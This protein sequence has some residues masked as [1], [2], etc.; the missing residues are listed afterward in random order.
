MTE[1]IKNGTDALRAAVYVKSRRGHLAHLARDLQIGINALEEFG[2]G[3]ANLAAETKV[4]MGPLLYPGSEYDAA[5]DMMRSA[6]RTPPRSLGT[7]PPPYDPSQHPKFDTSIAIRGPV[8]IKT[9]KTSPQPVPR[10]GWAD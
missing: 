9:I 5:R 1:P 10:P 8:P 3:R 4:A 7:A 2:H 6:N